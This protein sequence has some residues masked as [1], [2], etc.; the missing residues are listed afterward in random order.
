MPTCRIGAV[1]AGEFDS[2]DDHREIQEGSLVLLFVESITDKRRSTV[3]YCS[4]DPMD[5]CF[6]CHLRVV[7]VPGV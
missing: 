5:C 6:S 3:G 2:F 1:T 4:D 7:D